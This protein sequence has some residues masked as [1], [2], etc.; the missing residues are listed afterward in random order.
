MTIKVETKKQLLLSTSI[1]AVLAMVLAPSITQLADYHNF[2]DSSQVWGLPHALNVLSN[3]PFILVGAVGIC[4]TWKFNKNKVQALIFYGA[5]LFV[6]IGSSYYH[7]NPNNYTLIW[8]RLPMTVAFMSLFS[9]FIT[10]FINHNLG[11]KLLLPLIIIGLSSI[12]YWL[13]FNDLR[14]YAL[15]QFYPLL[16]MCIALV[17]TNLKSPYI[18]PYGLLILCYGLAKFC[19]AFD[20]EI[21]NS[22][23]I[24]SGHTLK[25]LFATLGIYLFLI[26]CQNQKNLALT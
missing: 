24:I 4:F 10:E 9:L 16:V 18:I 5:V 8:D 13:I 25:H 14:V 15:V 2:S 17:F 23:S 7:L 3:L 26:T 20:V 21:H 19:E 6:G 11:K 22:L 12:A 1:I